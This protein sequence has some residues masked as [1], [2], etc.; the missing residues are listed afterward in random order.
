MLEERLGHR[1]RSVTYNDIASHYGRKYPKVLCIFNDS[2][3]ASIRN[4]NPLQEIPDF[5]MVFHADINANGTRITGTNGRYVYFCISE[6]GKI[7][8]CRVGVNRNLGRI[9]RRVHAAAREGLK[10]VPFIT[11]GIES[12]YIPRENITQQ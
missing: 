12:L 3:K 8:L 7:S 1:Y 4:H 2:I 10:E 5:A 9:W 6:D 11:A